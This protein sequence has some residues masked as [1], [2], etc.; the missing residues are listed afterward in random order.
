MFLVAA[1]TVP[2]VAYIVLP[3]ITKKNTHTPAKLSTSYPHFE[4]YLVLTISLL[5]FPGGQNGKEPSVE[6]EVDPVKRYVRNSR[7]LS[8]LVESDTIFT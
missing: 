2:V 4:Q 6:A 3:K 5:Y 8:R 1:Y 7:D